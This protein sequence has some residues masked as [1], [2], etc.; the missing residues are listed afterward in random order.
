MKSKFYRINNRINVPQ[1]LLVSEKESEVMATNEALKKALGQGLDLVEIVPNARPPVVKIVDFKKFLFDEKRKTTEARK[2]AKVK[3]QATKEFRFGPFIGDHDLEMRIVRAR[4]FLEN[5]D[6]VK[7]T[8]EFKGREMTRK[9][10]GKEKMNKVIKELENVGEIE[11][12]PEQ[13]GRYL[14]ALLKP[15][16]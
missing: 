13:K 10:F 4:G 2:K 3:K 16:K 6:K 9:D 15:K 7:I 8:V 5:G 11:W 14:S 1:V 12:G